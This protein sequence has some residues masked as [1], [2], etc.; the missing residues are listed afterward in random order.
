MYIRSKLTS[1]YLLQMY[2]AQPL[3]GVQ[4]D[5][6][7]A[8]YHH[9]RASRQYVVSLKETAQNP[10]SDKLLHIRGFLLEMYAFLALKLAITPRGALEHHTV[11]LDPFLESLDF[12]SQYKSRGFLLGFGHGL[13]ALIPEVSKIVEDRRLEESSNTTSKTLYESYKHLVAKLDAFDAFSDVLEG[14]GFCP[15]F[16]QG[17]AAA[18]YKSAL[19]IYLHSAFHE[20]ILSNLDLVA[21]IEK[22]INKTL[23]L[24]WAIYSSTSPLRR[25][26][27]WPAAIIASCCRTP[28][29]MEAFRYGLNFNPRAT[30]GVK[31]TATAVELLWADADPRAYGPR[32]LSMVMKKHGL[33]FSMC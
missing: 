5:V 17:P 26:M 25:M 28:I 13:F 1:P 8:V 11:Q 19:I 23:P 20:D 4:G 16:E 15:A 2:P 31:A 12:L 33:S 24:C 18:I 21:E 22:R 9:I 6:H 27:L 3:Q 14:E 32:G 29:H 10:S 7:G 30:G